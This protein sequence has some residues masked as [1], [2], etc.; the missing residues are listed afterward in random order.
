MMSVYKWAGNIKFHLKLIFLLFCKSTDFLFFR[1]L[2]IHLTILKCQMCFAIS[3]WIYLCANLTK[4]DF[5]PFVIFSPKLQQPKEMV[6]M[7][8]NHESVK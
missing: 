7:E 8:T 4:P 1:H 3:W 5:P 2:P 6:M